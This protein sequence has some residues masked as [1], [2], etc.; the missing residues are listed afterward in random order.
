MRSDPLIRVTALPAVLL[1]GLSAC[2]DTTDRD[3]SAPT[4]VDRTAQVSERPVMI[5]FDGPRFNACGRDGRVVDLPFGE[6]ELAVRAAPADS[7]EEV[8]QVS[9]G[10]R[11]AMCQRTGGWVGIVYAPLEEPVEIGESEE[12]GEAAASPTRA[13][14]RNCGTAAPV[15]SVRAYDGPCRS[16]WVNENNIRLVSGR[17]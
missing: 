12:G 8:D 5:G 17:Q 6:D 3:E 14:L 1:L 11:V 9:E 2:S 15:S 7:A 16:G 10:T 4:P 13:D